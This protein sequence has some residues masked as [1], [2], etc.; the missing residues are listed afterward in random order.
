M[1]KAYLRLTRR[2]IVLGVVEPEDGP[3]IPVDQKMFYF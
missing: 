3:W 1:K 2:G